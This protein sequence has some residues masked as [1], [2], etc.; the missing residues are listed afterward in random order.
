[1]LPIVP[2]DDPR[3]DRGLEKTVTFRCSEE[4]HQRL[5]DVA[6]E[7]RMDKSVLL[8]RFAEYGLENIDKFVEGDAQEINSHPADD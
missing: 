8:R 4:L 3:D 6:W 5:D 2:D 7:N 1:M